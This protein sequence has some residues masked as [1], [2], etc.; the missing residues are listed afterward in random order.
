MAKLLLKYEGVTLSSYALEGERMTIGRLAGND[1]QLDDPAISGQHACI[2]IEPSEYLE[3][4]K[5]F[6][7]E[8]LGST[9]GTLVNEEKI[10]R[11]RL[12]HGDNIQIGKHLFVFD[13]EQVE[14]LEQTAIYIPDK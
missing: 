13:S 11:V 10:E 2:L 4:I 8:D 6:Y 14:D 9:N 12:N 3:S 5:E 1:I 7:I